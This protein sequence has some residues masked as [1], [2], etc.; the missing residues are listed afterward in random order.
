[1]CLYVLVAACKLV[2]VCEC[3]C[4]RVAVIVSGTQSH[5]RRCVRKAW[6]CGEGGVRMGRE[7][8]CVSSNNAVSGEGVKGRKS[9]GEAGF[10]GWAKEGIKW[11]AWCVC[12][13]HS[14]VAK[15]IY[16]HGFHVISIQPVAI[17]FYKCRNHTRSKT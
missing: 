1:M 16:Y 5:A 3:V 11:H 2:C 8:M 7:G 12:S 4:M 10:E 9:E 15:S 6:P 13:W 17:Q 14:V